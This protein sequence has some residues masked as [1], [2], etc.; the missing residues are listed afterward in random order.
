[1]SRT[2]AASRDSTEWDAPDSDLGGPHAPFYVPA[3]S[4]VTGNGRISGVYAWRSAEYRL[5]TWLPVSC[6]VVVQ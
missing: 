3:H 4:A 2:V 1:M 6:Q 5:S